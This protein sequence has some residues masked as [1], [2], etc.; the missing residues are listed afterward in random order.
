VNG[1]LSGVFA[2]LLSVACSSGSSVES[3]GVPKPDASPDVVEAAAAEASEDAVEEPL[4]PKCHPDADGD[5]IPDDV[6]GREQGVDTDQDGT[7]D[8]LDDDSDGDSIPDLVEGDT[9]HAGCKTPQDS[10]GDGTPDFR[11]LDSDNNGLPDR[12]EVTPDGK[13]YDPQVGVADTDG[14]KYPN[15]ADADNDGDSLPDTFELNAGKPVDTDLDGFADHDDADADGDTIG[16]TFE[17]TGDADGDELLNFRD[18]DSD[19]DGVPDACEAGKGHALGDVPWD[20]DLDGKYDFLDLDSDGDGLLD[21]EEDKNGNCVAD[22]GE[23]ERVYP[24]TDDDGVS[25]LIEVTLGSDPSDPMSTPETMGQYYFLMPYQKEPS[26]PSRTVPVNTGLQRADVAFFV[27]TTGTMGEE[28]VELKGGLASMVTKLGL[29]IPDVGLG[30][31]AHDD[32]PISPYGLSQDLPFYFPSAGATISTNPASAL[33]A[34]S[35]LATH[36]GGDLAESQIAAMY[37]GLTNDWLQWPG[38]L[39]APDNVPSGRFGAMHFRMDALPVLVEITDAPFHNGRRSN[40]PA[41]LHDTYSFNQQA[42][43]KPAT[44]D[45]LVAA[46]NARGARF[47]G[48]ASDDGVRTGDPY[49]D[50]AWIAD[51]TGSVV[52]PKAFGGTTCNTGLGGNALASGPDGPGGTCRL[53]FDIKKN[54]TGLTDRVIDGVKALVKSLVMDVRVVAIADPPSAENGWIDSVETFVDF[55]EVLPGGDP[56]DPN[57]VCAVLSSSQ[58]QDAWMGPKGLTT[59]V[60]GH[61]DTV[62]A[63][64]S[65]IQICF[66]LQVVQNTT[67]EQQ[68]H[69]QKFHAVLQVRARNGLNPVELDFGPPRDVLFLIPAKPQ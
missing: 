10:D 20:S 27:D 66:R 32:F 8:Y 31:A 16:D 3:P 1:A 30:V 57:V 34:V 42:P 46:L 44:A 55:V 6:E 11:D 28:I 15:Y 12:D 69:I 45:T 4:L 13:P 49:Q 51:Q 7:P 23:T 67:I 26:P 64:A 24:D 61:A 56:S 38:T 59:G 68:D 58:L 22:P 14:D 21:G 40:A 48:I 41:A 2:A 9:E 33:A 29:A 65:G 62:K 18:L 37:R 54:G 17:G 5:G 63:A 35:A 52:P 60:D 50:M 36:D 39:L 47:I 53:V 19:G 43:Y 25:D